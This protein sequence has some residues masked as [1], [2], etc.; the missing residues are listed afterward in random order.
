[1]FP[2]VMINDLVRM[3]FDMVERALFHRRTVGTIDWV[4]TARKTR[5]WSYSK[6]P[7]VVF[8]E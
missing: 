8:A 3:K 7:F 1:M 6:S 2:G 5:N 4:K